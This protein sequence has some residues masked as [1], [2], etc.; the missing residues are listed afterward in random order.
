MAVPSLASVE[1]FDVIEDVGASQ[2]AR[3]IDALLIR[4]FFRLLE[5]EKRFWECSHV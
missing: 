5:W 1:H 2:L 4:C 3:F